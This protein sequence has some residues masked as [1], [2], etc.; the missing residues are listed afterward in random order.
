MNNKE[1]ILNKILESEVSYD[2]WKHLIIK[3]FLPQSFYDGILNETSVYVNKEEMKGTEGKGARA[4]HVNINKSINRFPDK[5]NE[6]YL[7]EY[8][9]ILMDEDV[10]KAIR[11]KV[12]LKDYHK[13]EPSVDMWGSFDIQTS[14]FVYD[15]V[16][17][18]HEMKM[19]T[20]LHYL[21]ENEDDESL[22]TLLYS[23]DKNRTIDK[24]FKYTERMKDRVENKIL[25]HAPFLPNHV[26]LFAPCWKEGYVTN[27]SMMH[28]SNKTIFRKTLQTFWVKE[29]VDWTN[30]IQKGRIKL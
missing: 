13:N 30:I 8:Y 12:M 7:T 6:P 5:S 26:L 4:Y 15:E 18:D 10:E 23:P 2:P 9:N 27:H 29:K 24:R 20:M 17:P 22:G 28:K 11:D 14:G 21:P 19:I 16:H 1:Y 3:D 25:S